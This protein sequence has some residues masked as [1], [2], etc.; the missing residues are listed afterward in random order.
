MPKN[1][2]CSLM[3]TFYTFEEVAIAKSLL[4][5]FLKSMQVDYLPVFTERKGANKLRATVDDMLGL[6][7]LLDY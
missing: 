4:F 6:F 2:L 7:T 3:S 1:E 5:D